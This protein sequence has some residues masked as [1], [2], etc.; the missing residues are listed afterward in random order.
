MHGK[1]GK[2]FKKREGN[3]K[4]PPKALYDDLETAH[5][6]I[7][8]KGSATS[9]RTASR[10][11]L[12]STRATPSPSRS[13]LQSPLP[14][15][16]VAR[17]TTAT[18]S[19][20]T[21]H[22]ATEHAQAHL[23]SNI[24]RSRISEAEKSPNQ[25]SEFK[26]HN[27][28]PLLRQSTDIDAV[29]ESCNSH[30]RP[31][32]RN[33]QTKECIITSASPT[34]ILNSREP[35][36]SRKPRPTI[37]A[38]DTVDNILKIYDRH[39]PSSSHH[40]ARQQETDNHAS[41]NTL[42]IYKKLEEDDDKFCVGDLPRK[43]TEH[44]ED[45]GVEPLITSST[46][47]IGLRNHAAVKADLLNEGSQHLAGMT[48]SESFRSNVHENLDQY[49]WSPCPSDNGIDDLSAEPPSYKQLSKAPQHQNVESL[50]Y[51]TSST[52]GENTSSSPR[53]YGNTRKL[54][55][56]SDSQPSK[57]SATNSNPSQGQLPAVRSSRLA[58]DL[59][60]ARHDWSSSR[61]GTSF[62]KFGR[63]SGVVSDGTLSR[64][65]SETE[66]MESLSELVQ[67]NSRAPSM[68]ETSS[69]AAIKGVNLE[70][71]DMKRQAAPTLLDPNV[72]D[73]IIDLGPGGSQTTTSSSR[74]I[75][76]SHLSVRKSR[77]E[78][79][80]GI[81]FPRTRAA[82]PPGLFGRAVTPVTTSSSEIYPPLMRKNSRLAQAVAAAGIKENGRLGRALAASPEQDWLTE[83][84]VK[85]RREDTGITHIHSTTGSSLANDSDSGDLSN[86]SQDQHLNVNIDK[87]DPKH[88]PS[89]P[90]Y[91]HSWSLIKDLQTGSLS[92]IPDYVSREGKRLPNIMN[93][94]Q[95][96]SFTTPGPGPHY[97]HPKPLS[98]D[99]PH[100]LSSSPIITPSR[101]ELR[102][103]AQGRDLTTQQK[104]MELEMT[105]S[106]YS[107]SSDEAEKE[108]PRQ[109]PLSLPDSV[110]R[111]QGNVN[112][113]LEAPDRM[114]NI[115][116]APSSIWLSTVSEAPTEE[117]SSPLRVS[118]FAK[119]SVLGPKGNLTGTPQGYGA[120]EVGSSLADNSSPAANFSSSPPTLPSSPPAH[121]LSPSVQNMTPISKPQSAVQAFHRHI[122]TT[123]SD[124]SN[125]DKLKSIRAHDSFGYISPED[126]DVHS[127]SIHMQVWQKRD[128]S[129]GWKGSPP[130]P[131]TKS[132]VSSPGD[133]NLP[134][135]ALL[136]PS[137]TVSVQHIDDQ[138]GIDW[139]KYIPA[140][141]R[142]KKLSHHRRSPSESEGRL[143]N[144]PSA[145]KVSGMQ[146][147]DGIGHQ[148]RRSA[149]GFS[150]RNKKEVEDLE[151][152]VAQASEDKSSE[153]QLRPLR[154]PK[155]EGS[156]RFS[157]CFNGHSSTPTPLL[158]HG[159]FGPKKARRYALRH[160]GIRANPYTRPVVRKESPHLYSLPCRYDSALYKHQVQC[161]RMWAT[162]CVLVPF[163]GPLF[164]HGYL[165]G[166]MSWHSNGNIQTFRR[167]E[168]VPVLIY[169]YTMFV[170][171]LIAIAL[172]MIFVST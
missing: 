142:S 121:E 9:L 44:H 99:H 154:R 92:I 42:D 34:D 11:N 6:S 125:L 35:D 21:S 1:I 172:V 63:V 111:G 157:Y 119:M 84:D 53:S 56:I 16:D 79:N 136:G 18:E 60:L 45:S 58:G 127:P 37:V 36:P 78:L 126:D 103:I 77:N 158:D 30:R 149:G 165:D 160:P 96:R 22:V 112:T 164:G 72:G 68:S 90:R 40:A 54:L 123:D 23:N 159:A 104:R 73:L 2:V 166:I 65:M 33:P 150:S 62:R 29:S 24:S 39:T 59:H 57:G 137:S 20:Q 162:L 66:I 163:L 61:N 43:V 100:P 122:E 147:T 64:P 80:K 107:Y 47:A 153:Y 48:P 167:E 170:S 52:S 105:D 5:E 168:K 49:A 10:L 113:V 13:S 161:S 148:K 134:M 83:T 143:H 38:S 69:L 86:I 169:S 146:H 14:T 138:E 25:M 141:G 51:D 91:N 106:E 81:S 88:H 32:D 115:D 50:T 139:L 82:T 3:E 12:P 87:A 135:N 67:S 26:S 8:R 101:I 102:E 97:Q 93:T 74:E 85:M 120:R 116:Q 156:T 133:N 117:P 94:P 76:L 89:H 132:E 109:R 114:N 70:K 19:V 31:N 128:Q 124:Y 108:N 110:T 131:L 95:T 41:I 140:L 75:S 7:A 171:A 15:H 152:S 55:E 151:G 155:S 4:T 129:L 145:E 118:S 144:A 71:H 130:S 28:Q 98:K 46:A 27:A 17:H